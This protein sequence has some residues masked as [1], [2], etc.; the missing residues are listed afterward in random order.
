[1]V[2]WSVN[3]IFTESYDFILQLD[4][5]LLITIYSTLNSYITYINNKSINLNVIEFRLHV[6]W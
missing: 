3:K 2:L 4:D 6:A 5:I 1:M